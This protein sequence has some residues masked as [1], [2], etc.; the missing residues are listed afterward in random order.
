MCVCARACVIVCVCVVCACVIPVHGDHSTAHEKALGPS[1][2]AENGLS[3]LYL[4]TNAEKKR[5]HGPLHVPASWWEGIGY[6]S[7]WS[8]AN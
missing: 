7:A 4:E 3:H 2:T 1:E 5:T 8:L 6:L